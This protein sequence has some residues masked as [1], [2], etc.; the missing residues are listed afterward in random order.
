MNTL[1]AGEHLGVD[2]IIFISILSGKLPE[3]QRATA[4]QIGIALA[5]VSR[6]ALLFTIAWIVGLTQTVVTIFG[7]E[8]SWRDFIL[9]GGGLFL[10][11]KA[12]NELHGKLEG[13]ENAKGAAVQAT[14]AA[15]I[16][17]IMVL[18][19]VFALDSIITAV[20][21]T[22][23]VSIMV[24]AILVATAVMIFLA[25]AIHEFVMRHPTVKVLA[26]AFLLLIG[27]VLIADGFGQSVP[28]GYIYFAM[29]FAVFIELMNL[30]VRKTQE[31]PVRLH[32]PQLG[33]PGSH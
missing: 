11:Y 26:L 5:A 15:V 1:S 32:E 7:N 24:V 10:I 22:S 19:M 6:L 2:N 4:R 14:F 12:V 8:L 21:M 31:P 30:R 29:G 17:Q 13:P 18:D 3:H 16:L 25:K 33:P 27:M 20:G 28:K 9:I 23:H